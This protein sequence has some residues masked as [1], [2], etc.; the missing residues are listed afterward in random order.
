M[1]QF[2]VQYKT[3]V[4]KM[5]LVNENILEDIDYYDYDEIENVMT[6]FI[7]IPISILIIYFI[8]K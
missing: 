7:E 8:M 3:M 4:L 1:Y 6:S 2:Q 5:Q